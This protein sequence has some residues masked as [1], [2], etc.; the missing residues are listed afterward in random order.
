MQL[1]HLDVRLVELLTLEPG[2]SNVQAAKMLGVARHTVQARLARLHDAGVIEGIVPRLDPEA[3]GYR[4]SALCRIEIDQRIGHES[5]MDDLERI[6]EVLDLYTVT[7]DFDISMRVVA[8][9]NADL[10]RVFDCIVH[11]PGVQRLTSSIVLKTRL[12]H[13]TLDVFRQSATVPEHDAAPSRDSD[14]ASAP[15]NAG[16]EQRSVLAARHR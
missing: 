5:V 1:D 4:Q 2:T 15:A 16:D 10:Q 12:Q 13:R 8:T 9:S 11:T 7:G 6:P 3:F 14:P